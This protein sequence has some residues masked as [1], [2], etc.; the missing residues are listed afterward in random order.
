MGQYLVKSQF[1]PFSISRCRAG[2]EAQAVAGRFRDM[3]VV[4]E[5]IEQRRGH[6]GVTEDTPFAEAEVGRL[7]R[8]WF[9]HRAG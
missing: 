1:S 8:R 7:G 3:A 6:L 4:R 2:F 5:P 9:A